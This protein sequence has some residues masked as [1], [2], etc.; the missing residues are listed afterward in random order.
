MKYVLLIKIWDKKIIFRK[1]QL[2]FGLKIE[3]QNWKCPIFDIPQS[4][5]LTRYQKI[6]LGG[7]MQ[8]Y[9]ESQQP[10]W[11]IQQLSP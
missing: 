8:K 3:S 7:I 4:K 9:T 2:N 1:I 11:E 6:L 10:H 5:D